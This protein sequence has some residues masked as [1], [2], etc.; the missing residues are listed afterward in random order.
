MTLHLTRRRMIAS[1]IAAT[2]LSAGGVAIMLPDRKAALL[3]ILQRLIGPFRIDES[4]FSNFLTDLGAASPLPSEWQADALRLLDIPPDE[5]VRPLIPSS[6]Q[7]RRER[8]ERALLTEFVLATGFPERVNNPQ[9][10]YN[11]L[12]R[13]R[14]CANP[15]AQFDMPKMGPVT[16][17]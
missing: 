16:D 3:E 12:F 7:T 6:L 8:M 1:V 5:W 9:L 10:E 4:E 13:D 14:L 17:G 2:A 11:G 15:F